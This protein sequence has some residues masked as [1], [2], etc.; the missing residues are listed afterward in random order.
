MLVVHSKESPSQS[1]VSEEKKGKKKLNA[2]ESHIAIF[3]W[4]S[5]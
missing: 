4:L 1:K 2:E 5:T 3:L